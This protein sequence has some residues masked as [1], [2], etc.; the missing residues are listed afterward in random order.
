MEDI[1][2]DRD[3]RKVFPISDTQMIAYSNNIVGVDVEDWLYFG[4]RAFLSKKKKLA[5]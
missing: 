3:M 1:Q 2:F 4:Q 5:F